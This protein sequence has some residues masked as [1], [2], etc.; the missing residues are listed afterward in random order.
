[1]IRQLLGWCRHFAAVEYWRQR[2]IKAEAREA[3][4]RWRN[5]TREDVFVSAAV[6]GSRGMMGLA[7]RNGPAESPQPRTRLTAATN[8]W[9]SLTA[10][11]RMEFQTQWLPDAIASG[12]GEQAARARFMADLQQRKTFNDGGVN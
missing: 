10:I 9:D 4:E 8:P 2:A 12:V 6:L 5:I 11:E 7:P 3:A 1:M